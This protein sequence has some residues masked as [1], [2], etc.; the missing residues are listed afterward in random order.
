MK[1]CAFV[2]CSVL[3]VIGV[4]SPALAD[5]T[6]SYLGNNFTEVY[7]SEGYTTSDYLRGWLSTPVLLEPGH[8]YDF[9]SLPSF[10]F[11]DGHHTIDQNNVT[12][13]FFTLY[14]DYSGQISE[15][16][17]TLSSAAVS[18][19]SCNGT[20]TQISCVPTPIDFTY[21]FATGSGGNVIDNPGQWF[22]GQVPEPS[23]LLMLVVGAAG[24]AARKFLNS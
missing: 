22:F 24:V 2:A 20:N 3:L 11:F 10:S 1:K 7:G 16:S 15:W 21:V 9:F 12:S 18:M 4:S 17:V 14:V 8:S 23:S 13:E 5:Y 6:Y 19:G